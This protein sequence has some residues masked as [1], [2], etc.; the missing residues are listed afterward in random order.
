[1][2]QPLAGIRILDLSRLTPGPYLTQLLADLG[3]EV[4]K[5][6]TPSLGDYAR[7][8]PEKMGLG[9][10]F[11]M[12][13][14][15]KKSVAINY[16]NPRGLK[17]F[18]RLVAT[19]DVVLEGF[20]PGAAAR[21]KI[22]YESLRTVKADLI[23]CSLSG[24][25]QEGPYR[26]RA[27][28]DL[29]YT[30]TGG[31]LALNAMEGQPP[32]PF[33]VP[34]ADLSG[35]MLAGIAILGALVGRQR[36]GQGAYLDVALLDGVLSWMIPQAG[37]AFFGGLPVHSGTQALQGGLACYNVY[38]TADGK[39]LSLGA[40]E[41]TFWSDFC[42][43]T[44]REDLLSRQFDR[45][46]KEDVASVFKKRSLREWLELFSASDGCVEPILSFEEMLSHP[47]IRA[48][49]FVREEDGQ[50]VGLNT[51]FVF[52]RGPKRPTPGLGEHTHEILKDLLSEQELQ[53]LT[54]GGIVDVKGKELMVPGA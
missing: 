16:R 34:V 46:I 20:R 22:D 37:A 2:Y 8:I 27:G 47:Q 50:P 30:A 36:T 5:V 51:P 29:N 49:G 19:A 25:G 31:A 48:R 24:Y 26:C 14:Q 4:I 54:N 40:L 7:S 41:P 11:E 35:A 9:K 15:G 17:T 42:K 43:V 12:I 39:Y 53:D 45:A 13:N 33:G 52:A 6:E 44:E 38:E 23:Y 10:M 3:A 28:H 32:V 1:M 18:L 21:W